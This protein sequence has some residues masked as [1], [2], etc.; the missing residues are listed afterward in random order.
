VKKEFFGVYPRGEEEPSALFITEANAVLYD[1]VRFGGAS[2]GI[3]ST[4]EVRSEV[5]VAKETY[6][7]LPFKEGLAFLKIMQA[8]QSFYRK[9]WGG[10]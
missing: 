9:A 3:I 4:H 2:A 8:R 5:L 10:A 1:Y 6:N 7:S